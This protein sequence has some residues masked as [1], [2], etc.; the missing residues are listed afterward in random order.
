MG[1]GVGLIFD[2]VWSIDIGDVL[3]NNESS[4]KSVVM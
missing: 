3:V 1:R 4:T 2:F